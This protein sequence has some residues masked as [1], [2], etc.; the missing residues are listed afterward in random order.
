MIYSSLLTNNLIRNRE[1]DTAEATTSFLESN[2]EEEAQNSQKRI[3][4]TN[5]GTGPDRSSLSH[6]N[7]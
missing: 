6:R 5:L 7:N 2:L 1:Y 4:R 3:S